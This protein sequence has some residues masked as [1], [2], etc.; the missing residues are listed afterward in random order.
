MDPYPSLYYTPQQE[1]G[2]SREPVY[3]II[4]ILLILVAIGL[5]V[6]LIIRYVRDRDEKDRLVEL[7]NPSITADATSITGSWGKLERETD[8][9]TLYV[10]EKPLTINADGTVTSTGTVKSSDKTGSNN[11]TSITATITIN[12]PYNAA[13]IVTADDTS[14]YKG[15]QRK[16]F[17]Q[18][19]ATIRAEQNSTKPK[20]FEIHDL[21]TPNGS[22]S[23]EGRYTTAGDIG[24]FRLGSAFT[25]IKPNSISDSF[26][27]NYSGME[28]PDG[29]E[30]ND[31]TS[32]IL[33]RYP[34]TSNVILADWTNHNDTDIGGKPTIQIDTPGIPTPVPIDNCIWNYSDMPPSGAEGTNRW[35]LQS[36]QQVSLTNSTLKQ[37]MCL[38]R[39]GSSLEMLDISTNTDTWFNKFVSTTT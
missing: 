19:T 24:L 36:S 13:L 28:L 29:T 37:D 30:L 7:G 32:S 23:E 35:C 15:F 22:V 3:I 21:D 38:A 16:V 1:T 4:I 6:W 17:T 12:T 39:N 34:G 2:S 5:G 31:E 9:V 11:S 14:N 25:D 10:S 33:C 18:E 26:I 20:L 27:I 8:K